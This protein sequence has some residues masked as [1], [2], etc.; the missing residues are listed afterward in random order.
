MLKDDFQRFFSE[1]GVANLS[2]PQGGAGPSSG[3]DALP[4]P[5][6]NGAV[7]WLQ[8]SRAEDEQ[9]AHSADNP[10]A[11]EISHQLFK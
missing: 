6:K 1:H 3:L 9:A 7:N 4:P 2:E 11:L 5:R 10:A 8:Q